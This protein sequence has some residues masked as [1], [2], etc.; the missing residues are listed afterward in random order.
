MPKKDIAGL[1]RIVGLFESG[2]GVSEIASKMGVTKQAVSMRLRAHYKRR[3]RTVD[4]VVTRTCIVCGT[5]ESNVRETLKVSDLKKLRVTDI[6][7]KE[8]F[9]C[10]LCE[11]NNLYLCTSCGSVGHLGTEYFPMQPLNEKN[12]RVHCKACNRA[13]VGIWKSKNGDRARSI[14][15]R[16]RKRL[17]DRRREE[18]VCTECGKPAEGDFRLCSSCRGKYRKYKANSHQAL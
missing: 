18:G 4:V 2:S 6:E 11:S 15:R 10:P 17:R 3:R 1:Y 8:K 7:V 5:E 16:Y 9:L 13:A 12:R 14:Y